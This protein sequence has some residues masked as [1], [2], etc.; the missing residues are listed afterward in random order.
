MEH[1][2]SHA[3]Y[4]Y[5]ARYNFL[6]NVFKSFSTKSVYDPVFVGWQGLANGVCHY[7]YRFSIWE[8]CRKKQTPVR[9]GQAISAPHTLTHENPPSPKTW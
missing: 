2:Y 8:A 1:H 9:G 5:L 4:A 7:G 6:C 3:S